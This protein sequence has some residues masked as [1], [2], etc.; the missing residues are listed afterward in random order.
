M[1]A[2][3]LP[4]SSA[5]HPAQKSPDGREYQSDPK[6]PNVRAVVLDSERQ[7]PRLQ[8]P[9][10]RKSGLAA[11]NAEER[12]ELLAKAASAKAAKVERRRRSVLRRDYLDSNYWD[13]LA[14]TMRVRLPPWGEPP[15]TT[16]MRK[17]LNKV[18]WSGTQY[19]AWSGEKTLRDFAIANPLWPAR[20]WAG[21]VLEQVARE[22]G[23]VATEQEQLP[24]SP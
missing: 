4:Q 10:M 5:P 23:I 9:E 19:L 16:V 13:N 6:T 1:S 22:R 2:T 24:L 11:M 15:T 8:N 18:G 17:F 20:A 14:S 12:A 7:T 21:C 3:P